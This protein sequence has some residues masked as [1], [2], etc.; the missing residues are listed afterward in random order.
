[1]PDR[2]LHIML[3]IYYILDY[4]ILDILRRVL[5]VPQ[6]T[7]RVV[8]YIETGLLDIKTMAD[9]SRIQMIKRLER[10]SNEITENKDKCDVKSG[11]KKQTIKSL[12]KYSVTPEDLNN[13]NGEP[14]Q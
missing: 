11:W 5:I 7:P 6:S 10:N 12:E 1:M 14:K 3:H 2:Y 8:L 9:I 4:D 13:T